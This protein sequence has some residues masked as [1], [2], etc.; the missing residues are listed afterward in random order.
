MSNTNQSATTKL[1]NFQLKAKDYY[2]QS[3]S[4]G[5]RFLGPKG[6]VGFIMYV[7]NAKAYSIINHLISI[8]KK[9]EYAELGLD[10]DFEM[11]STTVFDGNKFVPYNGFECSQWAEP[12]LIV[13]YSDNSNEAYSCWYKKGNHEII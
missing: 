7:D 8:G 10:G 4:F 13:Y 12:I 3:M 9:I 5:E 1:E 11:N 2:P 6:N